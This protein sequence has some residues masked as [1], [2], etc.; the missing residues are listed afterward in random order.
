M[1]MYTNSTLCIFWEPHISVLSLYLFICNLGWE[2]LVPRNLLYFHSELALS[3]SARQFGNYFLLRTYYT[4]FPA[5]MAHCLIYNHL[6]DRWT[7]DFITINCSGTVFLFLLSIFCPRQF[8]KSK[9]QTIW[10]FHFGGVR[11]TLVRILYI[12]H[13]GCLVRSN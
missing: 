12:F 1:W 8:F 6:S 9:P 2:P 7:G 4:Y 5:D 11:Y 3:P 10:H 13:K